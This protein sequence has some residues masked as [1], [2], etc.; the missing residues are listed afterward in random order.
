LLEEVNR[1]LF[2]ELSEVEMFIT[3]QLVYVN[4]ETRVVR[5]ANA[6]HCP[7][8][9]APPGDEAVREIS[10]DGMPLGVVED[11]ACE[12]VTL[13]WEPETRLLLYTDG[14]TEVDNVDGEWFGPGRLTE[15]LKQSRRER[16]KPEAMKALLVRRLG[17]FS[18]NRPLNDDQTFLVLSS[19]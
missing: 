3:A 8:L 16:L 19:E 6:G 9:L 17:E 7:L 2:A 15:W 14:V 1:L 5:V 13:A 11:M 4:G 18:S 10:P 12:E